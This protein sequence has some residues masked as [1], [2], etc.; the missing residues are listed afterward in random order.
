[1]VVVETQSEGSR[2]FGLQALE[3]FTRGFRFDGPKDDVSAWAT[4]QTM[5]EALRIEASRALSHTR[6]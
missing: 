1:M 4:Q 2:A 5:R 3:G 6:R